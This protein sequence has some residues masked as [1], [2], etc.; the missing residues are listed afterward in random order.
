MWCLVFLLSFSAGKIEGGQWLRGRIK[1]RIAKRIR[2]K[3]SK[4]DIESDLKYINHRDRDRS[5]YIYEPPGWDGQS[6]LPVVFL[7][8]GGGGNART[9]LYYYDLEKTARKHNFLLVA[10]NGSGEFD[11]VLLTW[12]V[13]FGFG[14]AYKNDV[15]DIG[16]IKKLVKKL[17]QD[18]PI[19][20]RRIYATGLSN[21]AIFCHLLAAQPGNRFAA[22]APVA[23]TAGGSVPGEKKIIMPP[24]PPVPVA[25]CM[26][27]GSLDKHT[28]V[29]GGIQKK[30]AGPARYMLSAADSL[31]WWAGANECITPPGI[32]YDSKLNATLV[33]Y[34][35]GLNSAPVTGYLIHNQGHA[36]PGSFEKPYPGADNPAP[37][38]PANEIIWKFFKNNPRNFNG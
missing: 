8:H 15:D 1:N 35:A 38:F 31:R 30:S 29:E 22:I 26:I 7:F 34:G 21:G 20:A 4:I 19:D 17:N 10:P 2:A 12:N 3:K 6:S 32:K 14:Y 5:Y 23:G 27:H 36:W 13:E 11:D 16:F 33:K 18:Y 37:Q 9:A 25:V 28:P 24:D